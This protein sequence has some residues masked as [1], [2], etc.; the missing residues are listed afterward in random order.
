[1]K[2][3]KAWALDLST[4][5]IYKIIQNPMTEKLFADAIANEAVQT[6]LYGINVDDYPFN[7]LLYD[8]P[9]HRNAAY[10]FL[11]DKLELVSINLGVCYIPEEYAKKGGAKN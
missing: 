10:Q 8:S 5:E 4:E 3:V 11:K 7:H 1:M 9:E 6:G 2:E